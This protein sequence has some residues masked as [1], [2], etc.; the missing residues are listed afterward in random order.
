MAEPSVS[1]FVVFV[2]VGVLLCRWFVSGFR[3]V[4]PVLVLRRQAYRYF[5]LFEEGP[6]LPRNC[7]FRANRFR[8]LA[9]FGGLSGYAYFKREVV[10]TYVRPNRAPPWGLSLR[11][12]VKRRPLVSHHSFRFSAEKELG[13]LNC[14][15]RFVEVRVG[16][17]GNVVKLE[18]DE[19]L[20]SARGVPDLIGL[21]CAVTFKVTCPVA[22]GDNFV[23]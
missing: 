9:F 6:T 16:A 2:K 5:R 1:I 23:L 15:R 10:D 20:F 17:R 19:F 22:G 21:D 7:T 14:F 13:A 4:L 11:F 3:R 12:P 18:G 8:A